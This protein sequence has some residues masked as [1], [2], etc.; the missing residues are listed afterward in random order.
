[1]A[2]WSPVPLP[3]TARP[4]AHRFRRTQFEAYRGHSC[5]PQAGEMKRLKDALEHGAVARDMHRNV[6]MPKLGQTLGI[7]HK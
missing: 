7:P 1:M 6:H 5:A 3:V 2:R 4:S